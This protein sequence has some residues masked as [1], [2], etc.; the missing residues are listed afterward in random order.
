[1]IRKEIG[2]EQRL[3]RGYQTHRTHTN[4]KLDRSGTLVE[5]RLSF[6]E[7]CKVWLDSGKFDQR[8]CRKGQYVMS[9]YD[10]LGHYEAGNVFIQLHSDNISQGNSRPKLKHTCQWCG[11]TASAHLINRWHND[12][13]KEAQ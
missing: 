4:N 12:N 6:D 3:R 5:F 9:R 8:G 2:L 7:W 13:C 10:D 1:M 11:K